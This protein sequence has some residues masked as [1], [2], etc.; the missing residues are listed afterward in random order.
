MRGCGLGGYASD[1]SSAGELTG[2][3]E[4]DMVVRRIVMVCVDGLPI[5]VG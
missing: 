3:L 5:A 1:G 2:E 4:G